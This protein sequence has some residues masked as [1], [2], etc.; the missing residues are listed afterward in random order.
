MNNGKKRRDSVAT[1][2]KKTTKFLSSNT[3][4]LLKKMP[5]TIKYRLLDRLMEEY[6][7]DSNL[8]QDVARNQTDEEDD[9]IGERDLDYYLG[10]R[11]KEVYWRDPEGKEQIRKDFFINHCGVSEEEYCKN[12][13][14]I[15]NISKESITQPKLK[16]VPFKIHKKRSKKDNLREGDSWCEK[17]GIFKLFTRR[18]SEYSTS[19]SYSEYESNE[20]IKVTNDD[21]DIECKHDQG[22]TNDATGNFNYLNIYTSLN[23]VLIL[24][25]SEGVRI[26][27]VSEGRP[28]DNCPELCPGFIPHAWRRRKT[29][30]NNNARAHANC[31]SCAKIA[32]E[33]NNR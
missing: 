12:Y 24:E 22:N 29:N 4:N 14:H 21:N 1:V 31:P 2:Y 32:Q 9:D 17:S 15:N 7:H 5:N 3:T 23:G 16:Q 30:N 28:C 11:K 13:Q 10:V 8:K 25:D 20:E 26:K 33:E 6:D 27:E 19:D 18:D